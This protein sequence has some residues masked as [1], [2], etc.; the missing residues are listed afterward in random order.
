MVS[1]TN[2]GEFR[3]LPG[4]SIDTPETGP[5]ATRRYVKRI[6]FDGLGE[7]RVSSDPEHGDEDYVEIPDLN[8]K[9]VYLRKDGTL[10]VKVDGE[11]YDLV[12]DDGW[13][14]ED[15]DIRDTEEWDLACELADE[16]RA[17]DGANVVYDT[18][19]YDSDNLE[20]VPDQT[21][22]EHV[23]TDNVTIT[24][25]MLNSVPDSDIYSVQKVYGL[26][27]WD[28]Y[29]RDPI[30][31]GGMSISKW[32][33][34]VVLTGEY[35]HVQQNSGVE[36]SMIWID[37]DVV[38]VVYGAVDND[39]RGRPVEEGE[40]FSRDRIPN[41]ADKYVKSTHDQLL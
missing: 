26:E 7:V 32:Y 19:H 30:D 41:L 40:R 8:T 27:P 14:V 12:Y 20:Y 15:L 9:N 2:I 3:D 16:F 10:F 31:L 35:I 22:V 38:E 39:G 11:T 5:L 25:D 36:K 28:P 37:P 33:G 1:V 6:N 4:V 23:D 24:I 34:Q 18:G 13:E 29:L 21:K 17:S